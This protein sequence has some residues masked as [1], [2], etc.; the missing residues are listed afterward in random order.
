MDVC[1]AHLTA[2]YIT[3]RN[4]TVMGVFVCSRA[5]QCPEVQGVQN[6][7]EF[8]QRGLWVTTVLKS[9]DFFYFQSLLH[10]II[11]CGC[12]KSSTKASKET[13]GIQVHAFLFTFDVCAE[14]FLPCQGGRAL[15]RLLCVLPD[16]SV[17][18]HQGF[19]LTCQ[20]PKIK[21]RAERERVGPGIAGRNRLQ[22]EI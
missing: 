21:K 2:L 4:S 10:F 6:S 5:E 8:G 1:L 17:F 22:I 20:K 3:R 14:Y 13:C 11:F 19:L 9:L 12:L 16:F 7:A 15:S 18:V